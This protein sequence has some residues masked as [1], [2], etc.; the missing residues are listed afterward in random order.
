M[1]VLDGV[2]FVPD[3]AHDVEPGQDGVRQVDVLGEG[4]AGVVAASDGIGRSYY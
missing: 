1:L 2:D 3:Y 4:H